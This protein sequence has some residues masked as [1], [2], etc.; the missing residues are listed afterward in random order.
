MTKS[1]KA[2]TP[3]A[4]PS[5]LFSEAGDTNKS[6]K[7]TSALKDLLRTSRAAYGAGIGLVALELLAAVVAAAARPGWKPDDETASLLADV[8]RDLCQAV[9]SVKQ[10]MEA[11]RA[12]KGEAAG[13]QTVLLHAFDGCKQALGE[14]YPFESGEA[15]VRGWV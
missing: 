11:G 7:P 4:V 10:E 5:A 14:E 2:V 9:V 6:W 8:D 12:S 13:V 3:L 1:T 15:E